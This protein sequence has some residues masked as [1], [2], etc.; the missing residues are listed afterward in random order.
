M[1][2]LIF[3]HVIEISSSKGTLFLKPWI[4]ISFLKFLCNIV[5]ERY[6]FV[7]YPPKCYDSDCYVG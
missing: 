2:F 1:V 4:I 6:T 5:D 7:F 3:M